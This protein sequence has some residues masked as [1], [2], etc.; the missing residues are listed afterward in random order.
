[1]RRIHS[2]LL[3]LLIVFVISLQAQLRPPPHQRAEQDDTPGKLPN[4]K[5]QQDEIL[6]ADHEK[7][8]ADA[9]ELVRLATELK[10]DVEKGD[11]FVFSIGEL[12]KT[13]EIEKLVKR[14]RG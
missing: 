3:V 6:K 2:V 1:M 10:D 11:P 14:I 7:D 9:R 8:V 4:G 12:K 13:D 5:S